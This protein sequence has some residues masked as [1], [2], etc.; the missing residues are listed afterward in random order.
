MA[1]SQT[2]PR[3]GADIKFVPEWG[4]NRMRGMLES[5]PDWCISRQRAW[6]L[7]IPAFTL[8]D[9]DGL[10]DRRQRARRRQARAREGHRRVVHR[11]ARGTAE[12]LRPD[13][14][15][16][17]SPLR[18]ASLASAQSLQ[19]GPRHPR[20]V[21]RVGQ[22]V[23]RL[24][25]RARVGH[26]LPGGSLPRRFGPASR[27]VP[28]LAA[29]GA[30]RARRA[31]PSST[32]LTHGFIVDKDGKKL[33]K[34]RPDAARYEVESLCKRV[35]HG[36]DALVGREPALRERHQGRP[37]VL[38]RIGRELP[39]GAQH[40]ALHAQ[41]PLRLQGRRP[42]AGLQWRRALRAARLDR[43]R[44]PRRLGAFR[45]RQAIAREVET[46]YADATTSARAAAALRLLQRHAERGLPRGGQGSP[47]LRQA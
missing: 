43:A 4:R 35:R 22:H 45:V 27:L 12:V 18:L 1:L 26:G 25:A 31:R 6:G 41:Q 13:D 32:L 10:H 20:R 17:L 5:R 44:Q 39:Q 21:V 8:P 29:A 37:L 16:R 3:G 46:G 40:A 42:R 7:P 11:R 19:E 23:E 33:S 9:G 38:R 47:V 34:S 15:S 14:R 36:R 2:S 28:E 30:G 24:H